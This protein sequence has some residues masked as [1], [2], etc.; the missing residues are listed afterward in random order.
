MMD[1]PK[2]YL[3]RVRNPVTGKWAQTRHK[4]TEQTAQER[5]GAESYERI[6]ATRELRTRDA[7][8][9]AFDKHGN[10]SKG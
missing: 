9:I 6:N 8:G 5:F 7:E 2:V 3:F 10:G 4:I 1:I